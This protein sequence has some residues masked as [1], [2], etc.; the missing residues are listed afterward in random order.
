MH[1]ASEKTRKKALKEIFIKD[2]KKDCLPGEFS[3]GER[4]FTYEVNKI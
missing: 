4:A 3:V 1:A 2:F